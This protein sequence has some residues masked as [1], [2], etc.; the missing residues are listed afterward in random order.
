MKQPSK[1]LIQETLKK[2]QSRIAEL[3]KVSISI[4]SEI[5]TY[6]EKVIPQIKTD[7]AYKKIDKYLIKQYGNL[8][9]QYKQQIINALNA[10]GIE[11]RHLVEMTLQEPIK[12]K[13]PL[14]LYKTL[15]KTQAFKITNMI[16]GEKSI[17]RRSKV[18]AERVT[19][20]ISNGFD[21]GLSI[22]QVQEKIDIELGFRDKDGIITAKSRQLIK[23]GK[24][25][26]T[27]GVIYQNYRIAR[28]EIHRMAS[29]Q[30]YDVFEDLDR[31][32]KRLKLIS[33]L[34]KRTRQQSAQMNNQISNENGEFKYPNGRYYRLGLQ[35]LQW[36]INDRETSVVVFV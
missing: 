26:H 12:W 2:E 32:D 14:I 22:S 16:L 31:E 8:Y 9:R 23:Q 35:P 7:K 15:P 36:S 1:K 13:E 25:A 3:N 5:R 4:L 19:K 28:T 17:L 11:Q 30:Q 34:D 24:F 21:K 6:L 29:I 27:N 18:L 10:S 20:I 33:I